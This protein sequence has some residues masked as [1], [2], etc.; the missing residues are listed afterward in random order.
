MS[1]HDI[2]LHRFSG[3]APF[4]F[5]VLKGTI[6]SSFLARLVKSK[7]LTRISK[8]PFDPVTVENED[9]DH[10]GHRGIPGARRPHPAVGA[11]GKGGQGFFGGAWESETPSPQATCISPV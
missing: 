11:L 6:V 2:V 7:D 8:H 10:P 1:K 9:K 3:C 5:F 4:R